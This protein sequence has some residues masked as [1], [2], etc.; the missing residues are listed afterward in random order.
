MKKLKLPIIILSFVVTAVILFGGFF[1]W[2]HVGL[3]KPLLQWADE[4]ENIRIE[5]LNIQQNKVW[6]EVSFTDKS[7]ATS[8]I[9]LVQ[10]LNTHAQGKVHVIQ[11]MPEQSEYHQWWLSHSSEILEVLQ[12]G[13]YTQVNDILSRWKKQDIIADGY[14]KMNQEYLFI[15]IEPVQDEGID[16]APVYLVYQISEL[17]GGVSG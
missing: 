7:F 14:L 1:T 16:P 8:Y 5:A 12:K 10:F 17:K 9:Q 4:Q 15:Y 3:E 2:Q 13:S 6:M 11:L